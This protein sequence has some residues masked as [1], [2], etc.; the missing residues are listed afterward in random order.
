VFAHAHVCWCSVYVCFPVP[1]SLPEYTVVVEIDS[2]TTIATLETTERSEKTLALDS[3]F[4]LVHIPRRRR[5]NKQCS[6]LKTNK[7]LVI[8]TVGR[9]TKMSICPT[10]A[11]Q[12]KIQ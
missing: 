8:M 12:P 6:T 2:L 10:E 5:N 3:G 4:N 9:V 7:L 1:V 11:E